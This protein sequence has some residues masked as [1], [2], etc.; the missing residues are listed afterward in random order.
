MSL[1]SANLL[2]VQVALNQSRLLT[3][4]LAEDAESSLVDVDENE[5]DIDDV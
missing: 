5:S 1:T 4:E 3:Q 2:M